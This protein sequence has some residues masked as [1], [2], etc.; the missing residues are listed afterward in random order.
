MCAKLTPLI[1]LFAT[2]A[3][4]SLRLRMG[5]DPGLTKIFP[6]NF[7]AIPVGTNYGN[8]EDGALN[9]AVEG[10]RISFLEE[11]LSG[12]LRKAASIKERL[13]FSTALIAGDA[14]ILDALARAELL[15]RVPVVFIDTFT[16]FPETIQHLKEIEAHYGFVSEKYHAEDCAGAE[17]FH[18]RHG[19]DLW[20]RDTD[21]YNRLCKVQYKSHKRCQ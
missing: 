6:R 4:L 17:E 20:M 21:Q 19:R 2:V 1:L 7:A 8:G 16:L 11:A 15:S 10:K 3:V 12:T 9:R 18:R 14:V 5:L 13:L